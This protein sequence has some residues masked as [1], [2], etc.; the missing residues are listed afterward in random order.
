[1]TEQR[2]PYC[3]LKLFEN[4]YGDLVCPNCGIVKQHEEKTDKNP[5]YLG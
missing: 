1:M 2:C 4:Q 5:S 3:G